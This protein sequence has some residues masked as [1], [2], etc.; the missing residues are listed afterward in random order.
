MSI[1]V[2]FNMT[3]AVAQTTTQEHSNIQPLFLFCFQV[4]LEYY[5]VMTSGN[6]VKANGV[7]SQISHA[8]C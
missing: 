5:T 6:A 7:V 4:S 3:V 8:P 2:F 1:F